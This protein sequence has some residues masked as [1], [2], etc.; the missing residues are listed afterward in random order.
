MDDRF[1]PLSWIVLI[2]L[3]LF[4]DT[5]FVDVFTRS[6]DFCYRIPAVCVA[7]DGSLLAF[8]E[9]RYGPTCSDYGSEHDVV[10]RRSTD[11]GK[12]FGPEQT[13][14]SGGYSWFNPAPVVDYQTNTTFLLANPTPVSM[15]NPNDL[16]C[17]PK[18]RRTVIVSSQD[19]GVTWSSQADITEQ[20]Q[21]PSWTG[22]SVSPGTG[23]Q[24]A[25]G[26]LL[27]PSYHG[28]PCVDQQSPGG[29]SHM[30]FSDDHGK[31]WSLG[32]TVYLNGSNEN[33][34]AQLK[35]GTLVSNLRVSYFCSAAGFCRASAA[36]DDD[37]VS[38]RNVE[39][40]PQLAD[41][42]CQGSFIASGGW[43][44]LSNDNNEDS[45]VNMTVRASPDGGDTWPAEQQ[46][47]PGAAGY[48]SLA[49][50]SDTVL[51]LLFERGNNGTLSLAVFNTFW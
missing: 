11:G 44:V 4:V 24:L 14:L 33:Q 2:S 39:L 7:P 22:Y 27:V 8:A 49:A 3:C 30:I 28:L 41:P 9:K 19:G 37:G 46:I 20:V 43:V 17:N 15:N 35:N 21:P 29:Y 48:S 42:Q 32:G 6:A 38:W 23:I 16:G 40:Q 18:A 47:W 12:T 26:R 51:A 50:L 31:S 1:R 36:S 10:I 34:V 45:R 25:S 13:I 5:A